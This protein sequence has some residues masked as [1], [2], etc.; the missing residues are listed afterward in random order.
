MNEK[1]VLAGL[2]RP[3]FV[4]KK[5]VVAVGRNVCDLGHVDILDVKADRGAISARLSQR[6]ATISPVCATIEILPFP[7]DDFVVQ[8]KRFLAAMPDSKRA[9]VPT[10]DGH[11]GRNPVAFGEVAAFQLAHASDGIELIW[12]SI[13]RPE[14]LRCLVTSGQL[15][16]MAGQVRQILSDMTPEDRNG[17]IVKLDGWGTARAVPIEK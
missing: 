9:D 10:V 15:E 12:S 7:A 14:A 6:D 4:P 5:G 11:E 8:A 1:Q 16:V 17:R 3:I 13:E 2:A